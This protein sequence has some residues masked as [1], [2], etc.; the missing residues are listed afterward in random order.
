MEF[1]VLERIVLQVILP[2]KG[3]YLTYKVIENLRND[4]AFSEKELKDYELKVGETGT[5]WNS[6]KEKPKEV[7]VGD[8]GLSIIKEALT[9]LDKEGELNKE[10]IALYE[11][12]I[13][14]DENGK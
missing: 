3:N 2:E 8:V 1:T 6:K 11:R 7:E 9:K 12:F 13:K 10:N 4:L 5:T 14:N